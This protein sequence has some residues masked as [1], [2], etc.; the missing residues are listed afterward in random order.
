M[1]VVCEIGQAEWRSVGVH[2]EFDWRE[3][4]AL[5]QNKPF[6][7]GKEKL[8]DL[9]ERLISDLGYSATRSRVITACIKAH[10]GGALE[11]ELRKRGLSREADTVAKKLGWST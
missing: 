4:N 2:L 7:S 10:V 3:L 8:R 11:N 6:Y 9:I 5:E 1:D